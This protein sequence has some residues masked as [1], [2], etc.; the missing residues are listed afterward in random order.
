MKYIAIKKTAGDPP[1][2]DSNREEWLSACKETFNERHPDGKNLLDSILVCQEFLQ[3]SPK[4]EAFERKKNEAQLKKQPVGTKKVKQENS[5]EKMVK[6]V[7]L[8]TSDEQSKK[9]H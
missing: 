8:V 9:K 4:W 7:L 3:E 6:R 2:G 5:D 1:S